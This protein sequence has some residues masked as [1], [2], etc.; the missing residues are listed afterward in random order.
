M[1]AVQLRRQRVD[2]KAASSVI[3]FDGNFRLLSQFH[4]NCLSL[5][6]GYQYLRLITCFP[7]RKLLGCLHR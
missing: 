7:P 2:S 4:L 3:S 1:S 6:I 5:S